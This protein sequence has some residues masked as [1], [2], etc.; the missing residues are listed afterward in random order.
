MES[1]VNEVTALLSVNSVQSLIQWNRYGFEEPDTTL[2]MARF[3]DFTPFHW[4]IWTTMTRTVF[5][6]VYVD[7]IMVEDSVPERMR[8]RGAVN[9]IAKTYKPDNYTEGLER[10]YILLQTHAA[11]ESQ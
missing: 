8:Q 3:G 6:K 4:H 9:A 10:L 2:V 7:G 11:V 1:F 5:F